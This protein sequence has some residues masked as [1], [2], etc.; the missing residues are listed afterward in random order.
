MEEISRTWLDSLVN[1]NLVEKEEAFNLKDGI[2]HVYIYRDCKP[3]D[4]R[5]HESGNIL[6]EKGSSIGMHK[7]F[8]DTETYTVLLGAVEINGK[9]YYAGE[10]ATCYSGESHNAINQNDGDSIM[11]F[12]K[13]M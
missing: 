1:Q 6:L 3:N 8:R 13:F 7:H 12:S 4:P 10:S 11:E 5:A 9:L 2:G